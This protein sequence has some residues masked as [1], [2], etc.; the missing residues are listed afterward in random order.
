MHAKKSKYDQ[1]YEGEPLVIFTGKRMLKLCC[2]DCGLVHDIDLK[3]LNNSKVQL[4]MYRN[5]RASAALRNNW[6]NE[7]DT[8]SQKSVAKSV[9]AGK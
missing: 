1:V 2:C 7:T 9:G 8:G 4:K 5:N 6:Y 3:V